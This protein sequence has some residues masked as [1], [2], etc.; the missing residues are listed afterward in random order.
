[1]NIY[2]ACSI[3]GG[4]Q[5]EAVYQQIVEA[6][7]M[8]GHEVP[9]AILADPD[10]VRLEGVV[11]PVEVYERDVAWIRGCD[12]LVAEL[13]TPSHGVGYEIAY[14]LNLS[15]PVLCLHHKKVKVS[16]MITGNRD[17]N[18]SIHIYSTPDEAVRIVLGHIASMKTKGLQ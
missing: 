7:L 4:R 12:L 6:L 11:R 8:D 17:P 10:V 2:F 13:S 3:T 18:L 16:K 14:A 9:T 5:D 1:M 15:K